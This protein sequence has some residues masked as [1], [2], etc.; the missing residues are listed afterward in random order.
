MAK[1]VLYGDG[2][3]GD[4]EKSSGSEDAEDPDMAELSEKYTERFG[5]ALQEGNWK[6]AYQA[7]CRL[8]SLHEYEEQQERGY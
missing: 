5:K 1:D 6:D 3:D 7:F 4:E 2:L 8:Q